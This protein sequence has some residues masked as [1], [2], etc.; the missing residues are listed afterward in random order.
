MIVYALSLIYP[1]DT[2]ELIGLFSVVG[3]AK[4]EAERGVGAIEW[5]DRGDGRWTGANPSPVVGGWYEIA[6]LEVQP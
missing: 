4:H 6:G 1:Y 2:T 5:K 3:S